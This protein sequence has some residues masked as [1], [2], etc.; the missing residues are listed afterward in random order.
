MPWVVAYIPK[1]IPN[2][3][4]AVEPGNNE[5]APTEDKIVKSETYLRDDNENEEIYQISNFSESDAFKNQFKP[6]L[7]LSTSYK[8][9]GDIDRNIKLEHNFNFFHSKFWD[10]N[11]D[12]FTIRFYPF[13]NL[14]VEYP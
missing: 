7:E 6:I 8:Y 10:W 2:K 14:N 1:N 3:G 13:Y 9:L 12:N 4:G 5:L 11:S